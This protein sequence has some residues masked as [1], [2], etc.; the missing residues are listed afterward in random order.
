MLHFFGW[1][2][3]GQKIAKRVCTQIAKESK[4]MKKLVIEYNMHASPDSELST[5]MVLD[6]QNTVW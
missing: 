5:D 1:D 4:Q 2:T 6:P 3:D